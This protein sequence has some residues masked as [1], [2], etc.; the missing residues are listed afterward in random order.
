MALKDTW[1]NKVDG[2]DINSADDINSVAQAVIDLEEGKIGAPDFNANEGEE[3]FIKN[4]THYVDKNGNVK[5]L[6]NKFINAEWMSTT[7]TVGSDSTIFAE[8]SI[9]F[10][11]ATKM[12]SGITLI[13]GQRC[14]VYWN[15]TPYECYVKTY[16][17]ELY[18]G[19]PVLA[20]SALDP[21]VVPESYPFCISY[22]GSSASFIFKDTSTAENVKLKIEG[23]A[24]VVYNKIP[25]EFLPDDIGGKPDLAEND[26]NAAGYVKNRTHYAETIE[27]LPNTTAT[28]FDEGGYFMVEGCEF[29][30]IVGSTYIIN[31]NGTPYTCVAGDN[32]GAYVGNFA[33][34]SGTG[35]TGEPFLV[36]VDDGILV[37][38]PLDGSAELTIG[39]IREVVKKLDN[40]FIDQP[41][42]FPYYIEVTEETVDN[43]T[44]F[45]CTETFAEILAL[46]SSGREI[47]VRR[48]IIFN[49]ASD[50]EI[51]VFYLNDMLG[52]G[53]SGV[54]MRFDFVHLTVG[55]IQQDLIFMPNEDGSVNIT[56]S[57]ID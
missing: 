49:N 4:R 26:P 5:K 36:V 34:L 35:D 29:E 2:K 19:N 50:F 42:M 43:V 21:D 27:L 44:T 33:L 47:K 48:K 17:T 45:S 23:F 37:A 13:E 14:I 28:F 10:T 39:V 12:V 24:T 53:S 32:G 7:K 25:K 8:A 38:M 57:I 16:A 18:I 46:Y 41:S 15:D 51:K 11:N 1:V 30:L 20:Y 40:K 22:F 9:P 52:M 3:G 6:D 31:W 56:D 55:G 54:I